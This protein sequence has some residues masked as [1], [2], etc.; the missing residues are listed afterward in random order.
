MRADSSIVHTW[1]WRPGR[2]TRRVAPCLVV[3]TL[4]ITLLGAPAR[5]AQ[6]AHV[7][8]RI[9]VAIKS[10]TLSTSTLTYGGCSGGYSSAGLL[11]FPN[12]TCTTGTVTVTNGTAPSELL[13]TG[14]NATPTD[15]GRSWAICAGPGSPTCS[16]LAPAADQYSEQDG[17]VH[18]GLSAA[19]D[20]RFSSSPCGQARPGQSTSESLTL[21]GPTSSTDQSSAFTTQITWTAT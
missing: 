19:C 3:A 16:A 21:H 2:A 20:E 10:V 18:I 6:S 1:R 5:S 17:A 11:G 9:S 8:A 14:A 4:V 7:T 12:G 13:I 15:G